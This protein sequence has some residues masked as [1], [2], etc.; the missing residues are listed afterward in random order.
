MM[1][2]FRRNYK[3]RKINARFIIIPY[4]WLKFISTEWIRNVIK[5]NLVVSK[6]IEFQIFN[7]IVNC[8]HHVHTVFG[9]NRKTYCVLTL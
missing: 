1:I 4:S 6:R 2:K 5:L 3:K 7:N 9:K 8:I